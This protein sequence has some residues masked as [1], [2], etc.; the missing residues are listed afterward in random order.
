[1][2]SQWN[3]VIIGLLS[4]YCVTCQSVYVEEGQTASLSC[5]YETS[6]ITNLRWY[7][8]YP[9]GKPDEII[10]VINDGNKTEGKFTA[11]IQK[12]HKTSFL[13]VTNT[14]V[15]DSASYVCATD[16]QCQT[17]YGSLCKNI[18]LLDAWLPTIQ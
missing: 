18:V 12:K 1:M 3:S 16:A 7:R 4:I 10:T 9:G 8:Q 5:T 11:E 15:T 17:S 2:Q 14:R 6:A 13:Y